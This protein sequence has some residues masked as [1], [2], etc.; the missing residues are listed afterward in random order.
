MPKAQVSRGSKSL[1]SLGK[2]SDVSFRIA[3]NAFK[4]SLKIHNSR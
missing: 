3:I 4:T 2:L 1:F